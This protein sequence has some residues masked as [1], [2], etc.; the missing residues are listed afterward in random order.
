MNRILGILSAVAG[1]VLAGCET[2]PGQAAPAPHSILAGYTCCNLHY[3]G[4]WISDANWSSMPMIPAGASIKVLDYGRYRVMTEIDGRKMRLGQDY[5]RAQPLEEWAGKLVVKEDPRQRI[6]RWPA[7]VREAARAG[8]VAIGMSKE[9]AIVSLG[10]P[11]AH[12]TPS[13]D[14]PQW[15]YWHTAL[16][17]YLVVWDSAGRVKDVIADPQTRHSVVYERGK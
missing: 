1:L 11:P 13:L 2:M 15:K 4:D 9:E 6:A 17:S 3:E 8:K 14:A 7:P 16:G 12:H 10:Y 5:G